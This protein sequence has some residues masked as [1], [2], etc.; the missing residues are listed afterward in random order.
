MAES[1]SST[2]KHYYL[3]IDLE[4]GG[5]RMPDHQLVAIGMALVDQDANVVEKHRFCAPFDVEKFDRATL[6]EFWQDEAKNPGIG[7]LLK[8]FREEGEKCG[9]IEAAIRAFVVEYDRITTQHKHIQLISN[10]SESDIGIL[11]HYMFKYT[12]RRPL[13]Y[14]GGVDRLRIVRAIGTFYHMVAGV[15]HRYS[16]DS[17]K[18][19]AL[20]RLGIERATDTCHDHAPE[21]DAADMAVNYVRALNAWYERE[22]RVERA[23]KKAR[24]VLVDQQQQQQQQDVLTASSFCSFHALEPESDD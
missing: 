10:N 11:N 12:D 8:T 4:R 1:T 19:V 9:S 15:E 24:K 3:A 17:C 18:A 6:V 7:E 21:N 2:E 16:N 5:W 20:K 13:G 23:V 22:S 14:Y